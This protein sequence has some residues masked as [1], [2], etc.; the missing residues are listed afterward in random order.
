VFRNLLWAVERVNERR[1]ACARP[2]GAGPWPAAL[3]SKGNTEEALSLLRGRWTS[4]W[5]SSRRA[6][7]RPRRRPDRCA[8]QAQRS[9]TRQ[10]RALLLNYSAVDPALTNERCSFWHFRFD[11]HADMRLAALVDVLRDDRRCAVST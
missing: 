2:G 4:A 7:A 3:D 8:G 11:A 9:A 5:P 1:V 6:T 10:R